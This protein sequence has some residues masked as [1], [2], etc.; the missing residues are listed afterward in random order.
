MHTLRISRLCACRQINEALGHDPVFLPTLPR[1]FKPDWALL[2]AEL[3]R[4][5][6]LLLLC[7]PGNPQGAK[8]NCAITFPL[9]LSPLP[10]CLSLSLSL[11][12]SVSLL[13]LA[14]LSRYI[15]EGNVWEADDMRR[16]VE[17]TGTPGLLLSSSA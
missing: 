7:N 13:S 3:A 14:S 1:T 4:G 6:D 12:L 9:S 17:L 16:L 2:E 11:S 5:L 8:R 15:D 10:L